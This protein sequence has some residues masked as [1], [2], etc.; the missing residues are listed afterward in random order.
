MNESTRDPKEDRLWGQHKLRKAG[1]GSWGE[2][3]QPGNP[4][5]TLA[6]TRALR[7]SVCGWGWGPFHSGKRISRSGISDDNLEGPLFSSSL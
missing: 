2:G 3:A 7:M 1:E 6:L 4:P 5:L